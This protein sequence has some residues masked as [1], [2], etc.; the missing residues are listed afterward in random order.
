MRAFLLALELAR[1]MAGEA[2]GCPVGQVAVAQV[3]EN[4]TAAGIEGGWYGD[5][6][7]TA[8]DLAVA[9]TW[10]AW[11]DMVGGALYAIGRGDRERIAALGYGDWLDS[12][13]VTGRFWCGGPYFVETL[14]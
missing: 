9:L 2:P 13:T 8:A 11:P 14:R 5:A 12:L 7:P 3:W 1:V 4:R 10:Q 6:D